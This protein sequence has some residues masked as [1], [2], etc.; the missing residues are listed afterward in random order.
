MKKI[1]IIISLFYNCQSLQAQQNGIEIGFAYDNY[2]GDSIGSGKLLGVRVAYE[3]TKEIFGRAGAWRSGFQ[4]SSGDYSFEY[5]ATRNLNYNPILLPDDIKITGITKYRS[6]QFEVTQK[7]YFGNGNFQYG[8]FYLLF[9]LGL[10]VVEH[11]TIYDFSADDNLYY[12]INNKRSSDETIFQFFMNVGAGYEYHLEYFNIFIESDIN[13]PLIAMSGFDLEL[14]D[15]DFE[16]R[17]PNFY[18]FT[19]GI[20]VNFPQ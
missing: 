9:G 17:S 5:T 14:D 7:M 18:G 11:G 3:Q 19:L 10:N 1:L 4:Y 2:F 16:K 12:D 20:R 15:F 6:L 8:G 13:A